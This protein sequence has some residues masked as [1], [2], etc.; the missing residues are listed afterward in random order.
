MANWINWVTI[1]SVGYKNW[2]QEISLMQRGGLNPTNLP[3]VESEIKKFRES[4]LYHRDNA[5]KII[6]DNNLTD[7]TDQEFK[8][9]LQLIKKK[10]KD[11]AKRCWHPNQG[12][13]C[14]RKNGRI[15]IINAHSV[16]NNKILSG[17]AEN[18]HV[19]TFDRDSADFRGSSLGKK[20]ASTF[21]GFCNKHDSIFYPVEIEEYKKSSEQHFLFAYRA[22]VVASHVKLVADLFMDYGNQS[23]KDIE[24]SKKIF[25]EA[26][27]NQNYN[28]VTTDVIE[29]PA[30]Y[31][32]AASSTFYLDFDFEGA[33]I[34]HSDDRME[35]LYLTVFPKDNK[36][37][38]LISY[39]QQD[40]NLYKDIANQIIKRN[41]QK[42]DVTMLIG[43]H[44]ENVYFNPTYF[45]TFI[46]KYKD[47]LS[48]L[49]FQ[50]QLDYVQYDS[51]GNRISETS[52]TP[53]NYLNN[54]LKIN[55][56]GY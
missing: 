21:L 28:V 39:L 24:E 37:F 56:F 43:A 2:L 48:K 30:Y 51:E 50:T 1:P 29:L 36:T 19:M 6:A 35:N 18:G 44:C 54:Q 27:L 41:K 34:T 5:Q 12:D 8:A 22:F 31:P 47:D 26:I 42:L 17:I 40:K 14:S 16:Q 33:E 38:V 15:E 10:A 53:S 3:L 46:S 9:I 25:D 45:D 23:N 13:E 49:L 52:M 11:A 20:T 55:F 7:I 4:P 32:I